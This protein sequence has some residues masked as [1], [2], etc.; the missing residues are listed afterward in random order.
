MI[1]MTATGMTKNPEVLMKI[2]ALLHSYMYMF[3]R[4]HYVNYDYTIAHEIT[5]K[6]TDSSATLCA[7]VGCYSLATN[8]L[9]YDKNQS[10]QQLILWM[11]CDEL[12]FCLQKIIPKAQ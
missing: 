6:W 7:V 9:C 1:N 12:R 8:T 2:D 11:R 10:N 5:L 4:K 3:L